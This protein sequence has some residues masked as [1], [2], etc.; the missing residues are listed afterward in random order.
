MANDYQKINTLFLRDE[1]NIIIPDKFTCPEFHYLKDCLWECTEK[2]DGTNIH[3][4]INYEFFYVNAPGVDGYDDWERHFTICG[5]TAKAQIPN[6]LLAKLKSIFQITGEYDDIDDAHMI[7]RVFCKAMESAMSRHEKSLHISIYGEGYGSKIQKGGNYIKND[8][9]FILFDIKVNDWWLSRED[10]EAIA[11]ELEI[12]IVPLIGYMTIPEAVKY[13]KNGFKSTIAEN[14]DYDAE[15]LV[16]KTPHG[17][18][19]RNGQRI[20]TKI[21]TCDFQKY[22]NKYGDSPV[23]QTPNPSY[24]K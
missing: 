17:L 6:H 23:E 21:K 14:P 19:F 12:P 10:C 9:G 7:D 13:V 18:Q 4:D 11:K 20:I 24:N 16:L 8:V 3:V 5:R 15:G 2:I 22:R 1:S